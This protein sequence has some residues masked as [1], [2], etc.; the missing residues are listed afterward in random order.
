MT[1]QDK[2]KRVKFTP[3][4]IKKSTKG[5]SCFWSIKTE[6]KAQKFKRAKIKKN[7]PTIILSLSFIN[8]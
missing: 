4:F 5:I 6:I 2:K 8:L 3:L 7:K 1:P